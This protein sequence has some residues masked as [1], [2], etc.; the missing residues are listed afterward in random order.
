[1]PSC[2]TNIRKDSFYPQAISHKNAFPVL[3]SVGPDP[4]YLQLED[5]YT[6]SVGQ[7]AYSLLL[8]YIQKVDILTFYFFFKSAHPKL[9]ESSSRI[10]DGGHIVWQKQKEN[11][12]MRKGGGGN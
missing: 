12:L 3:A 9:A 6:T 4:Q 8:I 5:R 1:M 2:K 7:G 10:D 11:N